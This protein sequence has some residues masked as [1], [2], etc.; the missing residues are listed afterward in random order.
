VDKLSQAIQ[1]AYNDFKRGVNESSRQ[2]TLFYYKF[3]QHEIKP[4]QPVRTKELV[5]RKGRSSFIVVKG[6]K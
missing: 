3:G 6:V 2:V 5:G 1:E 4:G